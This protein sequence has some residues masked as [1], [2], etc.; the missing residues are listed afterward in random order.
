MQFPLVMC[1]HHMQC[2]VCTLCITLD[3]FFIHSFQFDSCFPR[4]A[5]LPRQKVVYKSCCALRECRSHTAEHA[6]H[7][8][9]KHPRTGS[10]GEL[11]VTRV[12]SVSSEARKEWH[13][14]AARPHVHEFI[15]LCAVSV[16]FLSGVASC[17]HGRGGG[18]LGRGPFLAAGPA[19][20]P[21]P[22]YPPLL[23]WNPSP[24]CSLSLTVPSPPLCI[25]TAEW[26]F[27]SA[28]RCPL[29]AGPWRSLALWWPW[30]VTPPPA[31]PLDIQR[32][33]LHNGWHTAISC[34]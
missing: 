6:V 30:R 34:N 26:V 25:R 24:T 19:V 17:C 15:S 7:T 22:L 33:P 32:P 21:P 27:P 9:Q 31:T 28:T 12:S 29:G 20:T 8:A 3:E 10:C 23:R 1:L 5:V 18:F 11:C 13:E 14:P 4:N 16:Q 2:R